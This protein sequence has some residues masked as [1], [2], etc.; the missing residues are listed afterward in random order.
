MAGTGRL[1]GVLSM[2]LSLLLTSLLI[3]QA[4]Q[5]GKKKKTRLKVCGGENAESCGIQ[6]MT[7]RKSNGNQNIANF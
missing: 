6:L 3:P 4:I 2:Q 7:I 1:A 5:Y